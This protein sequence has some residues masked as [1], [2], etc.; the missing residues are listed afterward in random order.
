[1]LSPATFAP[2]K[3]SHSQSAGFY[4]HSHY[5]VVATHRLQWRQALVHGSCAQTVQLSSP[6][7]GNTAFIQYFL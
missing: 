2:P 5:Q 7:D 1:V 4:D 6:S 3:G